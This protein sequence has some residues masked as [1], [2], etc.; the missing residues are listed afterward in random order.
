MFNLRSSVKKIIL[1]VTILFSGC[2]F[3]S[4]LHK[5]GNYIIA[6]IICKT[7]TTTKARSKGL[8]NVFVLYSDTLKGN[9]AISINVLKY[10]NNKVNMKR[11]RS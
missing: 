8:S 11:V 6:E 4:H 7:D 9:D 10:K 1:V 3:R 2:S 5:S